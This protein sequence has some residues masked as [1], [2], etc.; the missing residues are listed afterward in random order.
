MP[1]ELRGPFKLSSAQRKTILSLVLIILLVIALVFV[2]RGPLPTW[3]SGMMDAVPSRIEGISLFQGA[4]SAGASDAHGQPKPTVTLQELSAAATQVAASTAAAPAATASLSK[5]ENESYGE[6][7]PYL[8]HKVA[9]GESL[10][11]LAEGFGSTPEAIAAVN[12]FLPDPLW[13]GWLMVIPS[14]ISEPKGQ[15]S[16]EVY[17][18]AAQSNINDLAQKLEVDPQALTEYNTLDTSGEIPAGTWLLIMKSAPE[19]K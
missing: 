17:L 18:A 6:H 7:G 12:Q 15:P 14:G 19:L 2:I 1:A 9:E 11:S 10:D 13:E 5:P 16:F 3:L 8:I 4:A